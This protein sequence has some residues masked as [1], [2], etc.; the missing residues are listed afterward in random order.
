VAGVFVPE[1]LVQ[2]LKDAEDKSQAS[3]DIA[4]RLVEAMKDL[5]HGVHIMALGWES[6]IPRILDAVGL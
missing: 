3:I 6:K 1:P 5:C 2:E 4:I